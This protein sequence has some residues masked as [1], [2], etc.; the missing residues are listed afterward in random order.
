MF[1]NKCGGEISE[2]DVF[3]TNCGNKVVEESDYKKCESCGEKLEDEAEFCKYCGQKVK[4]D[5]FNRAEKLFEEGFSGEDIKN[6][7]T[8][9]TEASTAFVKD[10][11]TN[12]H[13]K[14]YWGKLITIIGSVSILVSTI[15]PYAYSNLFVNGME[16]LWNGGDGIIFGVAAIAILV[17]L[18]VRKV[19]WSGV[20][21]V[22]VI[23]LTI[24]E[25][26]NYSISVSDLGAMGALV[27]RGS[28]Y[29][30]LIFGTLMLVV[31]LVL[32]IQD[33]DIEK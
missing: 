27:R 32:I 11:Y 5:R 19:K 13:S 10:A 2:N 12:K 6:K 26:I 29:Y 25:L 14:T 17:L 23:G 18:Y 22:L 28:G 20:A 1:C 33:K 15:L 24:Y 30:L 3:C 31:G 8:Q 7:I 16:T 21:S 9:A 4:A